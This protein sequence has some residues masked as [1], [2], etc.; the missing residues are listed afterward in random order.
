MVA[1]VSVNFM[2]LES[3]FNTTANVEDLGERVKDDAEVK[4][5]KALSI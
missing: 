4:S 1:C 2:V 5:Y 3:A